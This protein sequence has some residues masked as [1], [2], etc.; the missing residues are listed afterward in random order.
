MLSPASD[1]V[2]DFIAHIIFASD[3]LM[4][5]NPDLLRRFLR[6][7]FDSVT[8]MHEHRDAAI[9]VALKLGDLSPEV[10]EKDYDLV[11]PMFSRDGK[12]PPAGLQVIARSLVDLGLLETEPDLSKTLTET[13]LPKS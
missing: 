9:K 7:W 12:F 5:K 10:T 11:L 6:G 2:K 13:F 8:Y 3:D 1:Y 4:Q